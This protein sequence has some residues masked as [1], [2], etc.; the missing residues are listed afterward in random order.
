VVEV[1]KDVVRLPPKGDVGDSVSSA[2]HTV[3]DESKDEV[4]EL[5][6]EDEV[7]IG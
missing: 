7:K 1:L 4:L 2:S 6:E 5:R 3:E